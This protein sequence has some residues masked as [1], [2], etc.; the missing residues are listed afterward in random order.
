MRFEETLDVQ[1]VEDHELDSIG[2]HMT[3][4]NGPNGPNEPVKEDHLAGLDWRHRPGMAQE[5]SDLI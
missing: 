1:F 4:S 3:N 2:A 5:V